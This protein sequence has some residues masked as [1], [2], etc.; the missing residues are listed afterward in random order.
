MRG[1]F[2]G[3]H[4]HCVAEYH[5]PA[6]HSGIRTPRGLDRDASRVVAAVH[7]TFLMA[8]FRVQLTIATENFLSDACFDSNVGEWY[9]ASEYD[10]DV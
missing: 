10:D 4:S 1:N 6:V 9:H 7:T 3:F 8:C 5:V 2:G